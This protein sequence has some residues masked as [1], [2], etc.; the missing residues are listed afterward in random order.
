MPKILTTAVQ[1]KCRSKS[2]NNER[3]LISEVL[4][5]VHINGG[6]K[7][8]NTCTHLRPSTQASAYSVAYTDSVVIQL[9]S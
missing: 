2:M 7:L 5:G 1:L 9:A 8:V 4:Q 3:A 6:H